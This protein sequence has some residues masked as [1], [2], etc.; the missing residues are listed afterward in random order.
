MKFTL[1]IVAT[2]GIELPD[3]ILGAND[4][5]GMRFTPD[6]KRIII[7]SHSNWRS[8]NSVPG[9]SQISLTNA[10]DTSSFTLDGGINLNT[11]VSSSNDHPRGVTFSASGLK[12]YIGNDNNAGTDQ[13]IEYDL[14]CPF[15]I[16]SGDCPPITEDEV[17]TGIAQAQIMIANRNIDHSI[18]LPLNR[19]KWIRRNKDNQNLTNLNIDFNLNTIPQLDNPLLKTL[20]K[21]FPEKKTSH[22]ASI[23]KKTDDKKQDVF[24]WSEGSIAVGR[25]GDTNISSTKKIGTEAITFGADKF[26]NNNGITGLA[27]RLGNNNVDVG[28]GGSNINTDTYNLTFYSTS[29]VKD[30]S[31]FFDTVFGFGKLKSDILT[32]VDGE[33]LTAERTGNQIYGT[34]KIKD[35]IKKNNFTLISSGSFDIG[36][37]I[38][39]SYKESGTAAINVKK[40][41]VSSRKLRAGLAVVED[42]SKDKYYIKRHGKLEY[43]ADIDRSSNF[44]YSYVSDSS[45]TF[46]E[47]L[48][49]G[50]LHNINGEVG[51]DII[52]P[53][54]FSIFILYERNQALGTGHTDNINIAIGYLPNKKT[55][56]AFKLEGSENVGSEYKISK[57]INDF[58][59]DFKL[60]NQE[61]LK[62]NTVN[63]ASVNLIRKF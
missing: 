30:D 31:K 16:I 7:I 13:V 54:S 15:N 1:S 20:V 25:V 39:G 3:T 9:I 55:N 32:V 62:P 14:A 6:G 18:K 52:L 51:I 47:K 61:V 37:T 34:I 21:K 11:G 46:N 59:I 41:K 36:H 23:K 28:T 42:I 49:S 35:E 48:H 45:V 17:R 53:D 63:E 60:N 56:Y 4:P 2:A 27:F 29:P 44:K 22:Q 5:G 38:L 33:N 19:L 10:F 58:E 40:Q 43:A 24:Y 57:N 12:L 8:S 26:T 50:S